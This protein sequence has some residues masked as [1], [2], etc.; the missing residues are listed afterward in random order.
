VAGD[1]D[2]ETGLGEHACCL[3]IGNGDGG[4]GGIFDLRI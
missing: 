4:M 1:W 2:G 3:V